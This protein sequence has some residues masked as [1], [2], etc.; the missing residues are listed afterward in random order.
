MQQN[1]GALKIV[2]NLD[3]EIQI[4]LDLHPFVVSKLCWSLEV[5]P[6]AMFAAQ[7]AP[8]LELT[9]LT[10][11]NCS[12]FPRLLDFGSWSDERRWNPNDRRADDSSVV[13]TA[14]VQVWSA[15]AIQWKTQ[16]PWGVDVVYI[17]Q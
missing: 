1:R 12:I 2:P 6:W 8:C 3:P 7:W 4:A 17:G 11:Q 5:K 9:E 13:Y 16:E 15:L 14:S 10:M